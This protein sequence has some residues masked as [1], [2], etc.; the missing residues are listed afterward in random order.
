VS[1]RQILVVDDDP[2]LLKTL[3][4]ILKVKGYTPVTAGTGQQ[5][6][7]QLATTTPVVALVDLK[8]EDMSGLDVVRKIKSKMPGTECIMG[9][10]LK[11]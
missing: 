11:L 10:S 4:N 7:E 6:L 3:S 5:G 8:L 1:A 9:A 2:N